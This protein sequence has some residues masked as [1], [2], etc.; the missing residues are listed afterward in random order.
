MKKWCLGIVVFCVMSLCGC[1]AEGEEVWE[2]VSDSIMLSASAEAPS[3][4]IGASV[5][6]E[7]SLVEAFSSQYTKIYTQEELG[8]ELTTEI[9]QAK[10]LDA[11][12]MELTGFE[13][14][15]LDVIRT[16][17]YKMPRY[18]LTWT[19]ADDG[20]V[21]SC[22]AAVIDDGIYYYVVTA[23]VPVEQMGEAR[24][25]VNEFFDSFGLYNNKGV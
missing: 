21:R 23:S 11:L 7:A 18:D 13:Q 8:Y 5:P 1:A 9:R 12:L 15:S 24:S 10:S 16:S 17:A 25:V 19:C 22:R 14:E 4:E 20:G 2:T 3:F 6:E